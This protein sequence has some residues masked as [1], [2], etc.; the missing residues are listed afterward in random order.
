MA[1]DVI[2]TANSI[3]K[4]RD[5][6]KIVRLALLFLLFILII[7]YIVLVSIY[8]RGTLS[9]YNNDE[10]SKIVIYESVNDPHSKRRLFADGMRMMTNISINWLP[11]NIN[12]VSDGAHNGDNYIAYTFYVENQSDTATNY[13]YKMSIDNVIKNA[14]E[15]IRVMIY[16]NDEK[17]VYA[18]KSS[19]T[20]ETEKGTEPFLDLE[21]N[22]II[23][24][25]RENIGPYELDKFT[26]V[27]WI[28]GDDPD[29]TNSLLGGEI[30]MH[31]DITE[32]HIKE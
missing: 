11:S 3:K 9:I 14:D 22:V 8:Q 31:M 13:W 15:A 19:T 12:N 20:G 21:N 6:K 30:K 26:I 28:E 24:K 16:R 4:W 29:C 25:K 27:I 17:T 18:K 23:L 5:I 10:N 32:N 7:L 1:K 2:K